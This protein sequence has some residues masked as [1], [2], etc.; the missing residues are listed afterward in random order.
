MANPFDHHNRGS[1]TAQRLA[2]VFASG[3]GQCH[4]CGRKL[5]PGDKWQAD[6]VHALERGGTDEDDNLRPICDGCHII[7]TKDDHAEAG[8][9]RRSYTKHVVP[10]GHRKGR[11][12]R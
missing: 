5:Y 7:K 10:G 12:W 9:M 1:M 11:G 4:V 8:H 2:R 3:N 6:H